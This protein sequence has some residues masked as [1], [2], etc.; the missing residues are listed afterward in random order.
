MTPSNVRAV[1]PYASVCSGTA[2]YSSA[3]SC[4][5]ITAKT[6]TASTPVTTTTST[7]TVTETSSVSSTPLPG[8]C[9]STYTASCSDVMQG[10][11]ASNSI[12]SP[13]L[14]DYRIQSA[15]LGLTSPSDFLTALGSDPCLTYTDPSEHDFCVQLL[16]NSRF[17]SQLTD[18][19]KGLVGAY[20]TCASNYALGAPDYPIVFNTP[21]NGT[22]MG[23]NGKRAFGVGETYD[24]T[25]S[26]LEGIEYSRSIADVPLSGPLKS[27]VLQ[28]TRRQAGTCSR[29][30]QCFQTCPDCR[31]QQTYCG[32][33][34]TVITTAV[35][36][37]LA[38][39]ANAAVQ[40]LAVASCTAA[41]AEVGPLA[42]ACG[43]F[44]GRAAGGLAAVAVGGVCA[45]VRISICDPITQRCANC[46]SANNGICD[47][48]STQCCPGETGTSC[49]TGGCCCC[50]RCQA[51]GGINCACTSAPC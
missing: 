26:M 29:T 17:V 36:G 43:A 5:G 21:N 42:L 49:G 34:A 33:Q 28:L 30:G 9:S 45:E 8:N 6:I 22:C 25:R 10:I 48:G 40:G 2:R 50:P 16:A 3:C 51:P 1:P 37:S 20:E 39:I 41:C 27:S 15:L 4:W 14:V 23:R 11:L 24:L 12:A 19:T 38:A 35:C 46:N 44:C 31:D 47:S 7:K 13:Q 18:I 32:T